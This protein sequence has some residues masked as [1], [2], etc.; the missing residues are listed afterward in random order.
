MNSFQLGVKAHQEGQFIEAQHH[1]LEYLKVK[2]N[3]FNVLQLIGLVYSSLGNNDKAIEYL[4]SSLKI[5]PRQA[6]VNNS[7]GVCQKQKLMLNDARSNFVKA[8]D[9]KPDYLDP[10][11]NL[12]RLLIEIKDIQSASLAIKNAKGKLPN[13]QD[14]KKLEANFYQSIE[15]HETAIALLE[16]VLLANPDNLFV[17]HS[18]ALNLRMAGQAKR[19]LELYNELEQDGLKRF[20]LFHN[21]ANAMADLG[22]LEGAI[23]YY[24]KAIIE[25]PAYID[26]HKNLNDLLWEMQNEDDFLTSYVKAFQLLP[27]DLAL[28]FSYASTLIRLGHYD[29]S[30]EFL[31]QLPKAAEQDYQYFDLLGAVY[32]GLG[33]K[34]SALKMQRRAQQFK[35]IPISST[36]NLVETLLE[37]EHY[38]EAQEILNE[39]LIRE[40]KNKHAW[41]LLGIAWK[42]LGDPR[43]KTLND[44]NN[45]VREYILDVPEGF[46]SIEDFCE[47]LS[48]YLQTLHTAKTQ[49]LEQTLSGGTQ[50]KGNLFNDANPLIQAFVNKVELCIRDY[51]KQTKPLNNRLPVLQSSESF[52]FSG[53][54]SVRLKQNGFHSQHVHPM[55]WISSAFYVKLPTDIEDQTTKAGWLKIGASNIEINNEPIIEKHIKPEIGKLVL[56]QSYMWHGT[57]PFDSDEERMTIAFDVARDEDNPIL[58]N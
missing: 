40:P 19:A 50:T 54:W 16:D 29:I 11:K 53:S 1:Y 48:S 45:L 23:E 12:I 8:I 9:L 22:H 52:H 18:L 26:S 34:T 36:I 44:Y 58:Q 21:K 6:H 35:D 13:H 33:D 32:K 25:N 30:L 56:F 3:D 42:M 55:G 2:P 41:A 5:N 7:L 57:I 27:T 20:Q 37:T 39:A 49:P 17:K 43:S 4:Q 24:R 51:I 14:I 10:H 28:R 38:R 47:E 31:K 46:D 15:D